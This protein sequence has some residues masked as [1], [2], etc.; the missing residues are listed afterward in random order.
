MGLE[1][2]RVMWFNRPGLSLNRP[3]GIRPPKIAVSYVLTVGLRKIE[4]IGEEQGSIA[5]SSSSDEKALLWT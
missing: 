3:G 4:Q 2:C 1:M 5:S